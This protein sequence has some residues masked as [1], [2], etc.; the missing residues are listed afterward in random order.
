MFTR[1]Q[2]VRN[3]TTEQL[4]EHY[5]IEKEL[6]GR[7][8]NASKQERRYLY[9]ILYDELF[10][11]VPHHPQLQRKS[12]TDETAKRIHLQMRFLRPFL[13]A[14]ATFLE[15]GAGDCA[16]SFEVAKSVK[17]AYGL[18]VSEE[19]SSTIKRPPNFQLILSDGANV[20][21]PSGVAVAYSNQVMEHLHPDDAFEQVQNIY[22]VLWPSGVY[23]CITPNRLDGPHDISRHF[24]SVPTGFHLREYTASELNFIFRKVG[25]SR[26][27]AYVGGKGIYIPFPLFIIRL[28]EYGL[29]GL[30]YSAR[31]TLM[32]RFPLRQLL[33]P[34]RLVGL[35]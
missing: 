12:S 18:D 35:K 17:T 16:L 2:E 9:S 34:V 26:T 28:L 25:F 1:G 11:R 29:K 10:R 13:K 27:R 8:R 32:A 14:E 22:N 15:I 23:I 24:D 7:L 31:K 33:V 20:P 4:R 21:V 5:E 19:I 6:A 30:P 3:R